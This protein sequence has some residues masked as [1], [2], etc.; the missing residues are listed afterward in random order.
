MMTFMS[1]SDM[2]D[3]PIIQKW[4]DYMADIMDV[5]ADNS[6]ISISLKEGFHMD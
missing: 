5:N 1:S 4:W 6:P 2:S 3:Y